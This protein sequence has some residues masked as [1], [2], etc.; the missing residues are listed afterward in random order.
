[1]GT[2]LDRCSGPIT[3]IILSDG[4]ATFRLRIRLDDPAQEMPTHPGTADGHHTDL[5]VVSIAQLMPQPCPIGKSDGSK[6]VT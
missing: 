2:R 1:M 6:P 3:T 5:L 4:I